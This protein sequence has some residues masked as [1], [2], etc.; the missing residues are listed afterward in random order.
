MAKKIRDYVDSAKRRYEES[1]FGDEDLGYSEYVDDVDLISNQQESEDSDNEFDSAFDLDAVSDYDE[2]E[3][4]SEDSEDTVEY[5]DDNEYAEDYEMEIKESSMSKFSGAA[6]GL[7]SKMK[8]EIQK[9][10]PNKTKKSSQ[11]KPEK[12][13]GLDVDFSGSAFDIDE[14]EEKSLLKKIAGDSKKTRSQ[15]EQNSKDILALMSIP[16]TFVIEEQYYLPDDLKNIEF[17][18][19][20]PMGFSVK[21]VERFFN[22]VVRT[23]RHYVDLLHKRNEHIVQLAGKIDEKDDAIKKLRYEQEIAQG[24]NV[25]PTQGDIQ[26]ENELTDV[27]L[28][29]NRLKRDLRQYENTEPVG[30]DDEERDKYNELQDQYSVLV[31]QNDELNSE[32]KSQRLQIMKLEEDSAVDINSAFSED[33][34]DNEHS[35]RY[36]DYDDD[37][38]NNSLGASNGKGNGGGDSALSDGD[39]DLLDRMMNEDR[40]EAERSGRN[41]PKSDNP[42]LE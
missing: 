18:Y 21:E 6:S 32:V 37:E 36:A 39:D 11:P 30:L 24:I 17:S 15:R 14:E 12:D 35:S 41:I 20:A 25:V 5:D 13:D 1:D 22:S 2:N 16:E 28:E 34:A 10:K 27:K 29:N 42:F 33:T 19:E 7:M 4:F 23:V 3:G 38:L 31:K 26:L 40:E 8:K 9:P